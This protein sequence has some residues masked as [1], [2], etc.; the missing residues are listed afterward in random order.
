MKRHH[1]IQKEIK[2]SAIERRVKMRFRDRKKAGKYF[3]AAGLMLTVFAGFGYGAYG[4]GADKLV[5]QE[6]KALNKLSNQAEKIGV[7][8]LKSEGM[9]SIADDGSDIVRDYGKTADDVENEKDGQ[10]SQN[11]KDFIKWVDFDIP[12]EA[13]DKAM[14]LDIKYYDTD[15]PMPWVTMLSVLACKYG[16]DFSKYRQSDLTALA[17]RIKDGQS[18][19]EIT[20]GLEY[21]NYYSEAYDAVLGGLVGEFDIQTEDENGDIKW[22]RKYGLKAF[23]PLA[24]GYDFSHYDDFGAQRTYGYKRRHL[25]HDLIGQVGTPVVAI[26]SGIVEAVGW[27]QYGGWR[28]GIRS[29]D[30]KRYYYY[31]H[32]RKNHPYHL[33]LEQGQTVMAGD[34]IGYLGRTGYSVKENVNNIET[35]H[36]HVGMQLIFDET[37][38]DSPTQI[39]IDM[40]DI[41]RLLSKNRSAVYK[42]EQ[43]KDYFRKLAFCEDEQS[44][45]GMSVQ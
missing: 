12:Y 10:Q 16:G 19:E 3:V 4:S 25:G 39:W 6:A 21:Y 29:F 2:K 31:A 32:L 40:Y 15:T 18:V 27:N 9:T 8:M 30:K 23:F 43:T 34:V 7:Y 26:E 28:I 35:P 14:K 5:R 33:N 41:S 24:A 45:G 17:E 44:A 22:E 42:N 11:K 38:K 36:L 20:E 1:I 13:L 37:Q